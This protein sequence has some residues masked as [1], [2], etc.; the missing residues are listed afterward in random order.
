MNN[1]AEGDFCTITTFG[2]P[3]L[4]KKAPK[5]ERFDAAFTALAEEMLRAMYIA[6]GIGI[7]A[8]QMG[9]SLQLFVIDLQLKNNA[10]TVVFDGRSL[11]LSLMQPFYCVNPSFSP[12]NDVQLVADE[13]CLS[14]PD[15]R[16]SVKRFHEIIVHYQDL[17]GEGHS[18]QCNDLF[19]RCIQH[20]SDHL[21]G[22]LFIDRLSKHERKEKQSLLNEIK[23]LGGTFDYYKEMNDEL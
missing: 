4:R 2:S 21:N 23:S 20:E 7:A 5:V 9:R 17:N 8:P 1:Q 14:L 12:V 15:V 22:I 19:A 10:D 18:L 6:G 11:P 3:I 13:G 16:G